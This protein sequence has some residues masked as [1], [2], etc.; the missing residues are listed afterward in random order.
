MDKR[1]SNGKIFTF[2]IGHLGIDLLGGA[3]STYLLIFYT[4]IFGISAY[5]AG[6]I[7]MLT[8][9]WDA[10]NDPMM[11]AIMD[12]T[13]T[14]WGKFRPYLFAAPFL[15]AIFYS[16]TFYTIPTE[17][18]TIK[19]IYAAVTYTLAGMAFTMFDVPVWGMIPSVTKV[20]EDRNK[21]ITALRMV[22][23]FAYLI[24]GSITLPMV[25]KLG[26]GDSVA[27]QRDGFFRLMLIFGAVVIITG[28]LIPLRFKEN[29]ASEKEKTSFI[30]RL[31][32]LKDN[33]PALILLV[34]TVIGFTGIFVATNATVYHVIYVV[35]KPEL[36]SA[37]M[38]VLLGAEF[39]GILLSDFVIK[40]MG[41]KKAT[42]SAT[43][44]VIIAAIAM[45]FLS[46][47]VVALFILS[48]IWGLGMAMP[49]VTLGSMLADS[50]D[51]INWKMNIQTSGIVFSMQSLSIKVA[52]AIAAGI[53]GLGLGIAKYDG[54]AGV[55]PQSALTCITFMRIGLP[56]LLYI[57]FLIVLK[58]YKLSDEEVVEIQKELAER[59][60]E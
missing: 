52:S 47:N 44:V 13:H 2:G 57:V 36:V 17:N 40:K 27:N 8:K 5:A 21:L 7:L 29:V 24:I 1:L 31:K 11:G 6:L 15:M 35:G 50:V 37:Y 38:F 14:K 30:Q 33:K 48:A 22:T 34:L 18:M 58:R 39:V 46:Q 20:T 9:I 59:E 32:T 45:F 42:V 19:V 25:Y 4:D 26:G 10:V 49:E 3:V 43:L 12:S 55:Q 23:S 41:R 16:L 56:I 60:S 53:I 28:L 51:Y 54:A